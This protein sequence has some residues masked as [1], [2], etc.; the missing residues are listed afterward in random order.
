MLRDSHNGI[1]IIH[2]SDS[3]WLKTVTHL[4]HFA[5]IDLTDFHYCNASL[6][7]Q[8]VKNLPATWET[9]VQFVGQEDPL[10]KE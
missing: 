10:E 4:T 1:F 5:L 6:V 9:P 7:T 8:L 3:L 2:Y